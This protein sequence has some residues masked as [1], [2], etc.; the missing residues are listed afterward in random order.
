MP[1]RQ[2]GHVVRGSLALTAS[3]S[4]RLAVE[5]LAPGSRGGSS[6][7]R[8]VGRLLGSLHGGRLQF[9]VPLDRAG[10]AALRRHH[11]LPLTVHITLTP[12]EGRSVSAVR[13]VVL[14]G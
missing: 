11:R 9:A 6:A 10:R 4:G 5:L 8:R 12:A 13:H 1:A 14:R 7:A 2:H 3:A